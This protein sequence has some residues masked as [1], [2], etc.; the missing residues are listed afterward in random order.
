MTREFEIAKEVE[1]EGTPEQVWDA[2]A[3]GPGIDAWFMGPH[4]VEPGV[5]G[6][7][8]LDLGFFQ[9]SSTITTWE[10]GKHFAYS[11]EKGEDGTFHA[12]EYL[13]EGRDQGTTVLRFVH[14]GILGDGWGDEY[15]DQSSHGWDMY[16]FTMA[17]YVKYFSGR[18]ATYVFAQA[19]EQPEGT[20]NW[21]KLLAALGV[22][23][24]FKIGDEVT[25]EPFGITGVVDYGLAGVF[26]GVRA[27]DGMYRFHGTRAV[28]HHVF[29]DAT[30]QNEKWKAFLDQAFAQA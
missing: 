15:L 20:D 11:T 26:L 3:T 28:G 16:L 5:G 12:M 27:A 13:I 8:T 4:T 22:P 23:A 25:L 10:P 21:P 6:R 30:G 1:V 7:M 18:R 29:G 19:P 2:I 17:S 14:S 9:E 24:D